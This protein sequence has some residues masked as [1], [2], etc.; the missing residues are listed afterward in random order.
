MTFISLANKN[1]A[2]NSILGAAFGGKRYYLCITNLFMIFW[3]AGQRCMA[4][5]VGVQF[6]I[7]NSKLYANLWKQA[8]LVGNA[9]QWLPDLVEGA[10]RLTVNGGFEKGVDLY[11]FLRKSKSH[12][13]TIEK[14]AAHIPR[15]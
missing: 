4:I 11:V 1:F 5:S 13:E 14:G 3:A 10:K 9:Q 7:L 6:D 15:C 2:I 12:I 8:V